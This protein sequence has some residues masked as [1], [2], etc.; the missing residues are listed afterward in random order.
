M[1]ALQALGVPLRWDREALYDMHYGLMHAP[2]RSP[3]DGIYQVPPGCYLLTDGVHAHVHT[4]WDWNYPPAEVTRQP[5][6]PREAV[7]RLE[8]TRWRRPC[9]CGCAP[10]CRS[11]VT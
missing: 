10:T 4:Y 3:F 9:G 7:E 11:P 6:D 1:K 2:S 8:R 5:R